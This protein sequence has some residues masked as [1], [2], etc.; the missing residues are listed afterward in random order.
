[1][2]TDLQTNPPGR[3]VKHKRP[4]RGP[5]AKNLQAPANRRMKAFDVSPDALT[6]GLASSFSLTEKL[7]A[8]PLATT[9]STADAVS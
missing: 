9:T 6:P 7:A 2:G 8:R 1:M 5:K 3:E 4:V